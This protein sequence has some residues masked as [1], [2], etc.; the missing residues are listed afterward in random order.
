MQLEEFKEGIKVKS[1]D[2]FK[3]QLKERE[4]IKLKFVV[5]LAIKLGIEN[6]DI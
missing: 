2:I 3:A 4:K 1:C 5:L 6:I